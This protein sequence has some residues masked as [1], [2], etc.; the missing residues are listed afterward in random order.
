MDFM[1]RQYSQSRAKLKSIRCRTIA[2]GA[3]AIGQQKVD[4]EKAACDGFVA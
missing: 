2:A 1:E 4:F 3:T